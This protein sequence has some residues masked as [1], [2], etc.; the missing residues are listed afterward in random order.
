MVAYADLI[1][2]DTTYL[3]AHCI[4]LL[5]PICEAPDAW[6][7]TLRWAGVPSLTPRMSKLPAECAFVASWG[8]FETC[9][10]YVKR[11]WQVRNTPIT[12]LHHQPI[13]VRALDSWRWR[14]RKDR[15][16]GAATRPT[17]AE[18]YIDNGGLLVRAVSRRGRVLQ[19]V[20]QAAYQE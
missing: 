9:R 17:I 5:E 12:A 16:R 13:R 15:A 8:R 3:E 6:L 2:R 10:A 14:K 4:S 19:T 7:K 11:G 18:R 1:L 20:E